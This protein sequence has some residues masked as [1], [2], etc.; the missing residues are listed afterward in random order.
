MHGV[1]GLKRA[2]VLLI[3][4]TV[5]KKDLKERADCDAGFKAKCERGVTKGAKEK[6]G[7][8]VC[9][10]ICLSVRS[11][12]YVVVYKIYKAYTA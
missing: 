6:R 9:V 1:S 7:T 10:D 12:R 3:K 4:S 5:A 2:D 11:C 8:A